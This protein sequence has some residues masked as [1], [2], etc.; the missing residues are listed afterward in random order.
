MLQPKVA[1]E[2]TYLPLT[3]SLN[4]LD[5]LITWQRPHALAAPQLVAVQTCNCRPEKL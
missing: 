2:A 4:A 3:A 5:K 1:A